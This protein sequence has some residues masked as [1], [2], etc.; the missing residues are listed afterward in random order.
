MDPDTYRY[1]VQIQEL[2]IEKAQITLKYLHAKQ[3]QQEQIDRIKAC[4]EEF[5]ANHAVRQ[6]AMLNEYAKIWSMDD[7][8]LE[9]ICEFFA[10]P[11][12]MI[13]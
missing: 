9:R 4:F 13:R 5:K 7:E 8:E 6:R 3:E 11:F 12:V 2:I 10:V 1:E